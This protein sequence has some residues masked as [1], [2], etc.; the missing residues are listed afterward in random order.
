MPET[1]FMARY[2][3]PLL[4]LPA[5]LSSCF[6]G[7]GGSVT[8]NGINVNPAA[9]AAGSLVE[10]TG[11]LTGGG[12]S[13]KSWSVSAG[14]LSVD[15]PD[16]GLVLRGT[17]KLGSAVNLDTTAGTV[18]WLAPATGGTAT[19]TLTIGASSKSRTLNLS[20]SPVSLSV[21]DDGDGKRVT[22]NASNVTDL[23]Q[24]AFRVTYT[25]AWTPV[26]ASQGDFLGAAADTI[27]FE[28]HDQNGF[29]PIAIS[30]KGNAGGVDGS[31]MLATIRFEP[32][33]GTSSARDVSAVPFG[34]DLV[35]LRTSDDEPISF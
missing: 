22:I 10:L 16:F 2:L 25:S 6:G 18:Y 11:D 3:T 15:P 7:G 19:V 1:N 23:Y 27:F 9:P 17:A 26:S 30:R 35:V 28:K 12:S 32:N 4:V 31:G 13:T 33:S 14:T 21:A 20:N 24:A 8:V 29:V 34:L 5:L